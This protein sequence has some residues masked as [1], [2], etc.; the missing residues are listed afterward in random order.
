[1]RSTHCFTERGT[2]VGSSVKRR[3]VESEPR[4][5]EHR[6]ATG[7]RANRFF[8]PETSRTSNLCAW[9]SLSDWRF[10]TCSPRPSTAGQKAVSPLAA[11]ERR[12]VRLKRVTQLTVSS[13]R[14]R[15]GSL[16]WTS[17]TRF[18][19]TPYRQMRRQGGGSARG[20]STRTRSQMRG[21]RG[22]ATA[23]GWLGR[24]LIG[25]DVG[26][27]SCSAELRDYVV[28]LGLHPVRVVRVRPQV[29]VAVD[30]PAL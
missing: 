13:G 2:I 10:E 26:F 9:K 28:L 25:E 24:R 1:M 8:L 6:S 12:N 3:N 15:R 22:G 19:S 4:R 20:H 23:C 14:G 7:L 5:G 16:S 21:F 30:I 18:G 29:D 11:A 17:P 27:R